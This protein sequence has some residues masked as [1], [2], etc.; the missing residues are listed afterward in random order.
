MKQF[1]LAITIACVFSVSASAGEIPMVGSAQ[2]PA[3]TPPAYSTAPGDIPSLGEPG[4]MPSG[5]ANAA[6]SALL[7]VLGIL[8]V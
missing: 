2:A 6:L 4:D 1:V 7:T 8:A 5:G 3:D